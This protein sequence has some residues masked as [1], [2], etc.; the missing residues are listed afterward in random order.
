MPLRAKLVGEVSFVVQVP[1]KP[2]CALPPRAS[3]TNGGLINRA[4]GLGTSL[5][6]ALVALA[7]HLGGGW[8]SGPSAAF[9]MLTLAAAVMFAAVLPGR[10]PRTLSGLSDQHR[11]T[12][13]VESW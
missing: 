10:G 13:E 2:N 11:R 9:A 8:L 1:W 4:R 6:V 5:S 12:F 7:L 3:G